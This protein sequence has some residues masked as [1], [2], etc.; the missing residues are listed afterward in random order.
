MDCGMLG[1]ML[2]DRR[3]VYIEVTV[4]KRHA[5]GLSRRK[6]YSDVDHFARFSACSK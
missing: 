2:G 3:V 6:A 1:C 5:D 4:G